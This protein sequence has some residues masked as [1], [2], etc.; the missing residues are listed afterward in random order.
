VSLPDSVNA[1]PVLVSSRLFLDFGRFLFSHQHDIASL[2][3]ILIINVSP[4]KA[5]RLKRARRDANENSFESRPI[6]V[7]HKKK[8]NGA[9]LTYKVKGKHVLIEILY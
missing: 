5:T 7:C 1:V 6:V 4:N 9:Y 8:R 3:S 2:L